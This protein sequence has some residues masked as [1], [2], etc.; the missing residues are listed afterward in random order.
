[1]GHVP[2]A[3]PLHPRPLPPLPKLMDAGT[4]TVKLDS[5]SPSASM[6]SSVHSII[7]ALSCEE[8][9]EVG[10]GPS[11]YKHCKKVMAV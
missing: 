5:A 10:R 3:P 1:M 9:E 2:L 6:S 11:I 8:E 7:M 4:L